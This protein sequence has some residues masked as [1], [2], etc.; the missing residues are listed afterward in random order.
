MRDILVSELQVLLYSL[1]CMN[2]QDICHHK[3]L[4]PTGPRFMTRNR[5]LCMPSESV[6]TPSRPNAIKVLA[7]VLY[8]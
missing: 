7:T 8:V 2:C 4:F 5:L 6:H 1:S 3:L